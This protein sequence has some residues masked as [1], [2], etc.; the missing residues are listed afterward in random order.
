MSGAGSAGCPIG[1]RAAGKMTPTIPVKIRPSMTRH[2]AVL[3]DRGYLR[4]LSTREAG[5]HFLI[6]EATW[7]HSSIVALSTAVVATKSFPRNASPKVFKS[8]EALSQ[9][10]TA[11]SHAVPTGRHVHRGNRSCLDWALFPGND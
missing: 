9:P 5:L 2:R 10:V 6:G 8:T 7:N 11:V 4:I 3:T 1:V